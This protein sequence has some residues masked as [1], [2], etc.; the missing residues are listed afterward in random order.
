MKILY[1]IESK[2]KKETFKYDKFQ[3]SNS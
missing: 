2:G 3:S 1:R